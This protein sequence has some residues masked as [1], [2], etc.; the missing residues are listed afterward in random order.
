M[1][2][3]HPVERVQSLAANRTGS[4]GLGY[5]SCKCQAVI[6][7]VECGQV[8]STRYYQAQKPQSRTRMSLKKIKGHLTLL[9]S[10]VSDRC[11]ITTLFNKF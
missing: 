4:S 10:I 3:V 7:G 5:E 11:R 8:F 2:L 6:E 9:L 1:I